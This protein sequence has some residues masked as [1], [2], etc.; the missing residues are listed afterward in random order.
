M[1][2]YYRKRDAKLSQPMNPYTMAVEVEGSP[3]DTLCQ[4]DSSIPLFNN[5]VK[6][7]EADYQHYKYRQ[8]Q[9]ITPL[10]GQSIKQNQPLTPGMVVEP[11]KPTENS[12]SG[13][14]GELIPPPYIDGITPVGHGLS[15][16]RQG[17][18]DDHVYESPP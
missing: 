15:T 6:L 9:F 1:I 2:D 16:F 8:N 14:S 5:H 11:I 12:E 10:V 18:L 7:K 13:S 4:H 3:H 17:H